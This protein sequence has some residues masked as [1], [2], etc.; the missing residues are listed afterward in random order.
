MQST[1]KSTSHIFSII[2]VFTT[3]YLL[4]GQAHASIQQRFM[5]IT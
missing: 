4:V 5:D 2:D 1:Q 3:D